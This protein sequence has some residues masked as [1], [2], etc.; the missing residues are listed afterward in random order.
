MDGSGRLGI[1]Q[2]K[3]FA[4]TSLTV[5]VYVAKAVISTNRTKLQNPI[6]L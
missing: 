1:G 3:P 2:P 6:I 5:H 4:Y